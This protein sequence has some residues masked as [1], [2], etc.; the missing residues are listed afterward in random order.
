[1][2]ILAIIVVVL[3]MLTSTGISGITALLDIPSLWIPL[4]LTTV[5]LAELVIAGKI[6]RQI[7]GTLF[8][9]ESPVK[10][11]FKIYIGKHKQL[12]D[13]HLLI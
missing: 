8:I 3:V 2:F 9:A 10:N 1:M 7:A 13:N 4:L 6:N 5:M 11:T 12:I